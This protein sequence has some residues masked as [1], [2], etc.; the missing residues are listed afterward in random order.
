MD[1]SLQ[2]TL[3]QLLEQAQICGSVA[4]A[5]IP[6][7]EQESLARLMGDHVTRHQVFAQQL[8]KVLYPTAGPD[9]MVAMFRQE[10]SVLYADLGEALCRAISEDQLLSEQIRLLLNQPSHGDLSSVLGGHLHSVEAT[11]ETLRLELTS[12]EAQ[13]QIGFNSQ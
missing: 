9:Q 3:R 11:L 7:M 5:T 12:I 4:S 6:L 2:P 10:T 1:N 8:G 13:N